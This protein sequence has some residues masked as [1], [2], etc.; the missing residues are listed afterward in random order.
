M[1]LVLDNVIRMREYQQELAGLGQIIPYQLSWA[2]ENIDWSRY[3]LF[4]VNLNNLENKLIYHQN[5]GRTPTICILEDDELKKKFIKKADPVIDSNSPKGSLKRIA[6]RLLKETTKEKGELHSNL[7]QD[8]IYNDKRVSVTYNSRENTL[9]LLG[10]VVK[11]TEIE[12]LI[13][14]VLMKKPEK[15]FKPLEL[16][17][18]VYGYK[19]ARNTRYIYKHIYSLRQK[20]KDNELPDLIK[21]SR[22][23]GYSW[24]NK[25]S[26]KK[27]L[28][29]KKNLL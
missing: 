14:E 29:S 26:L 22:K 3:N 28:N 20:L 1:I 15:S 2:K 24:K 17:E 19:S 6:K 18:E 11:L 5:Q 4:V 21:S 10:N 23:H 9:E 8:I 25:K 16:G 7:T 27:H 12:A 13:I